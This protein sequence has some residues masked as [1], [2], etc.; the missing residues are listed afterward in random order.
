MIYIAYVLLMLINL[1]G[2]LMGNLISFAS[3]LAIATFGLLVFRMR[4]S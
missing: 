1:P 2:M 3:T 4:Q